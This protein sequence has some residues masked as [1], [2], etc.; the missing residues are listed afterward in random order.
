MACRS[1]RFLVFCPF[2][3]FQ[4]IRLL[5]RHTNSTRK[6]TPRVLAVRI[7]SLILDGG[8]PLSD[9]LAESGA[10]RLPAAQ[11][12]AYTRSLV[13]TT[14]RHLEGVDAVLGRFMQKPLPGKAAPVR[15]A[16]R[17]GAAQLLFSDTPAYATVGETVNAVTAFGF[18]GFKGLVNAVL[19]KVAAEGAGH[20]PAQPKVPAWLHRLLEEDYG[21]QASAIGRGLLTEAP[22]DL[23]MLAPEWAGW[24]QM[25]GSRIGPVTFR[26][27]ASADIRTLPGFD[28]GV[29]QVQ[30]LA[31]SLP[32]L[33]LGNVAGRS[34]LDL[35]AAPGGKTAQLAA[36]GAAVTAVDRSPPRL[37][38]LEENLRRLRLSAQSVA[39]DILAWEP[40]APFDAILLDAPCSATGTVRRHPDLL[41]LKDTRDVD[42]M[43]SLQR[44]LLTRAWQWLRPGGTLVY[45]TCSLQKAEGE[46]QAEWFL[47]E[48]GD[49]VFAPI[50]PAAVPGVEMAVTP[51]GTLRTLPVY[52]AGR[53]GMDGFFAAVFTK[54]G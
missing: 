22:L 32:A 10:D 1:R 18:G 54:R 39:A 48:K 2:N 5:N 52:L 28:E 37:K 17:L 6:D 53:G 43:A 46:R 30:D 26:M 47:T 21:A 8:K 23:T 4:S 12:R 19:R 13:L 7:L 31:A 15:Q 20:L 29:W 34:V 16:L 44:A 49:A 35:C 33:L 36:A 11:D 45:A 14:L 41:Y 25:P 51:E 9:A 42:A 3:W 27:D 38:T 50:A 24:E 40:D